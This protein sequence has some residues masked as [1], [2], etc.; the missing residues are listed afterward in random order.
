MTGIISSSN[1]MRQNNTKNRAE[2]VRFVCDGAIP[3]LGNDLL[4]WRHLKMS[5]QKRGE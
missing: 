2:W 4:V 1:R 5:K 3:G